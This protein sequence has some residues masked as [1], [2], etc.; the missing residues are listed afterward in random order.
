MKKLF[1]YLTMALVFVACAEKDSVSPASFNSAANAPSNSGTGG[2]YARFAIRNNTM[3]VVDTENLHV[4]NLSNPMNPIKENTLNLSTGGVETIFLHNNYLLMGTNNGM[5]IYDI[6]NPGMPVYISNYTHVFACDPVV[7]EGNYAY[8]TLRTGRACGTASSNLL[9]VID[10]S[11]PSSPQLMTSR[12]MDHPYGLGIDAGTLFVCDGNSG[13]KIYDVSN[14]TTP[15]MISSIVGM[16]A[17]DVIPY[18]KN[19]MLVGQDGLYQYDY[20]N[21]ASPIK[22]SKIP[23]AP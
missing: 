15:S 10:I 7:A 11:N 5:L 21:P 3:Y 23:V 22:L 8:V 13:C 20:S 4:W 9:E 14:P 12:P 2:S 1:I 17:W 6:T 16:D 18:H 19:L